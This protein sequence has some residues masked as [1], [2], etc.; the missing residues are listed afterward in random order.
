MIEN[1]LH[2]SVF[3]DSG[4]TPAELLNTL[5][6]L[7]CHVSFFDDL[8]LHRSPNYKDKNIINF[9]SCINNT[10]KLVEVLRHQQDDSLIIAIIDGKEG[11]KNLIYEMGAYDYIST[12]IIPAEVFTRTMSAMQSISGLNKYID[13]NDYPIE[14]RHGVLLQ[15]RINKIVNPL[16]RELVRKTCAYVLQNLSAKLSLDSIAHAVLTNRN[17]LAKVFKNT[18]NASLFEWIRE[19]R[20]LKAKFLLSGTGLSIQK[21]SYE[22][23]YEDPANFATTFKT[24]F[25][26]SPTNFRKQIWQSENQMIKQ[27]A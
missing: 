26:V 2:V 1:Q 7:G 24:T 20:L 5:Q 27:E 11:R 17:T 25:S 15:E 18:M 4:D 14:L 12:P 8:C 22:V 6:E 23:G 13:V 3:M 21:I 19:Q 9:V 10:N 16:Q